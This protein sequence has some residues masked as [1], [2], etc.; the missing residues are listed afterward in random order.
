[1]KNKVFAGPRPYDNENFGKLTR[2]SFPEHIKMSDVQGP[3]L[4]ITT[5]LS[6]RIPAALHCFRN[7][8]PPMTSSSNIEACTGKFKNPPD[9]Y[10]KCKLWGAVRS[11]V[12]APSY[13]FPY[14]S[15]LDGGL[16]CNNPTLDA[17]TEA[18]EYYAEKKQHKLPYREIGMVVSVGTGSSPVANVD[19][20]TMYVPSGLSGIY[21]ALKNAKGSANVGNLIMAQVTESTFRPVDRSRAWCLAINAAFYRFSPSLSSDIDLAETDN[22]MIMQMMWEGHAYLYKYKDQIDK[23]GELLNLL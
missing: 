21:Q 4:I 3:K 10:D 13:F 18:T 1:M 23:L 11:S 15:Y 12:A 22:V 17:L 8:H 5:T 20:I 16:I 19:N 14:K 9:N 7:Y 6:N 2:E